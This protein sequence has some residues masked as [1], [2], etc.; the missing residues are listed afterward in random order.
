MPQERITVK[1]CRKHRLARTPHSPDDLARIV[2][3][4][5][6]DPSEREAIRRNM[7][8]VLPK[9]HPREIV[10]SVAALA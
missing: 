7:E 2:S 6:K 8:M 9:A 10:A 1:F 5:K 4:W 3:A